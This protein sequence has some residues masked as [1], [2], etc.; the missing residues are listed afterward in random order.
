MRVEDFIRRREDSLA[1]SDSCAAEDETQPIKIDFSFEM[2]VRCYK[3][4]AHTVF[5]YVSADEW[6]SAR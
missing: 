3:S 5:F 6:R 4:A 1:P 2:E